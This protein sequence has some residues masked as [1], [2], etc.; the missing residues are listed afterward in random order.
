[1]LQLDVSTE[2]QEDLVTKQYM[3]ESLIYNCL[4]LY[5]LTKR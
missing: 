1:M 5:Y 2:A 3:E 4:G